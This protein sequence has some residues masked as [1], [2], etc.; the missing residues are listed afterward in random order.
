[1]IVV[2]T[3]LPRKQRECQSLQVVNFDPTKMVE[4]PDAIFKP[5]AR[6]EG[7]SVYSPATDQ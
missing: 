2:P 6:D 1:M 4:R 7:L 3:T 5:W